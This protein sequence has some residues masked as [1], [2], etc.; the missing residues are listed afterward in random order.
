MWEIAMSKQEREQYLAGLEKFVHKIKVQADLDNRER[1]RQIG[2]ENMRN[3]AA[4]SANQGVRH[5]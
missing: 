2:E 5:G 4:F 1:I 3:L